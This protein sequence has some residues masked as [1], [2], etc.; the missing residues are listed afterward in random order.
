MKKLVPKDA[1]LIPQTAERVFEGKIFDVYQWQQK[2]FDG[3]EE[4]FEMLRRP[5][6]TIVIGIVGDQIIVIDDEQPNRGSKVGFPGGR[7]DEDEQPLASA[8]RETKEETGYEFD[9][10]RLIEVAQPHSK[11]EWFIYIYLADGGRKVAEPKLDA[12]EKIIVRLKDFDEVKKMVFEKAGYLDHA[13]DI[14]EKAGS[15]GGLKS[16]PEF[17]G[18]E[19]ER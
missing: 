5:D 6:T 15:F 1:V 17:S 12:G 11:L 9:N 10:W 2:M 19:I 16:L 4:T 14:F 18:Q 8:R 7:I 3:T 13:T